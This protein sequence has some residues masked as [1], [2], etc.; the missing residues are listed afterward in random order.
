MLYL[1]YV[2]L[3]EFIVVHKPGEVVMSGRGSRKEEEE[4]CVDCKLQG[5]LQVR[6][7]L[8]HTP[9]IVL[10]TVSF[11]T[12]SL[13]EQEATAQCYEGDHS[14]QLFFLSFHVIFCFPA[15]FYRWSLP[16][17]T[18]GAGLLYSLIRPGLLRLETFLHYMMTIMNIEHKFKKTNVSIFQGKQVVQ[19][20]SQTAQNCDR[21]CVGLLRG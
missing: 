13:V 20:C 6:L 17:S 21:G 3:T 11:E 19:I 14:R 5:I 8:L 12:L 10:Q 18:L 9:H 2:F 1:S 15:A 16:G 4:D 7:T